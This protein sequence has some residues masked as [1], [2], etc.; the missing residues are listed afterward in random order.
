KILSFGRL[1]AEC[2]ALLLIE[3]DR[4]TCVSS[5]L[6]SLLELFT[7]FLD[8]GVGCEST[9]ASSLSVAANANMQILRR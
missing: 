5:L 1:V 9:K 6:L 4:S 3:E 8:G 7:P 2:F